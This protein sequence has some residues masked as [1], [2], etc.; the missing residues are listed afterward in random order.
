MQV[1]SRS[2]QPV[3]DA[4][5]PSASVVL[6]SDLKRPEL[7]RSCLFS[8]AALDYPN[9][10]IILVDDHQVGGRDGVAEGLAADLSSLRVV[11][12]VRESVPGVSV[13]RNTGARASSGEVLAFTDDDV[14]ADRDW[15]RAIGSRFANHPDE[16]M[17]TG[18][19]LPTDLETDAQMWFERALRRVR[20]VRDSSPP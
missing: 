1:E 7:L 10:E 15:L 9:F 16:G 17:V 4:A 12:V 13:A 5:L 3:P 8:L 2:I 19:I 18:M 20:E 6:A 14:I 11:R